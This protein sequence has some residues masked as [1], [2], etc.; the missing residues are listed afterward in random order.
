MK[1]EMSGKICLFKLI[2]IFETEI[3]KGENECIQ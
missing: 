2:K 1:A 3:E